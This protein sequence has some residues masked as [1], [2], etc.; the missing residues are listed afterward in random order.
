MTSKATKRGKA[1]TRAAKAETSAYHHGNLRAELLQTAGEIVR[2]TGVHGLS[3]RDVARNAGVSNMAPYRHFDSKAALVA[4]L[5]EE[6]FH[7]LTAAIKLAKAEAGASPQAQFQAAGVAYV[8]F[9]AKHPAEFRLM[10]GPPEHFGDAPQVKEASQHAYK[11]LYD[12]IADCLTQ[13]FLKKDAAPEAI[14][15]TSWALVHGLATLIVDGAISAKT[16]KAVEA[17]VVQSQAL[18]FKGISA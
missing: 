9:A 18:L 10:F 7:G 16:N 13:G 4:A 2:N 3:L 12:C 1:T 15:Q 14:G 17:V 5:A 6:G 11:Q 8:I